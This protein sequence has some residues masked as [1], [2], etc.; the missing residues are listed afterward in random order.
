LLAA[1]KPIEEEI[2][3]QCLDQHGEDDEGYRAAGL[4]IEVEDVPHAEPPRDRLGDGDLNWKNGA[5]EHQHQ[6]AIGD[7]EGSV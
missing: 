1:V 7:I 3:H 6:G 2:G 4:E 5:D